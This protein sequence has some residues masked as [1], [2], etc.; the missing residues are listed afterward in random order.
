MSSDIKNDVIHAFQ[1][2]FAAVKRLVYKIL[3]KDRCAVRAYK[4]VSLWQSAVS[5]VRVLFSDTLFPTPIARLTEH[6]SPI[7]AR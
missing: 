3:L 2:R 4:E 6:G 7:S 5:V 1:H